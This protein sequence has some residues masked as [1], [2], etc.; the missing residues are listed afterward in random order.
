MPIIQSRR[1]FLTGL[2]TLVAAPAIVKVS[3]LMPVRSVQPDLL[4][5]YKGMVIDDVAGFYCPY[6][7]LSIVKNWASNEIITYKSRRLSFK[8]RY[9]LV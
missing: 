8:T 7:P 9:G 2:A 1:K 3:S 5:P 6:V 4:M